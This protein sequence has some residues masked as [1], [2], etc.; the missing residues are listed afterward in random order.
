M[1]YFYLIASLGGALFVAVNLWAGWADVAHAVEGLGWGVVLI[2]VMRVV[3]TIA[4]GLALQPLTDIFSPISLARGTEIRWVRDAV[5]NL[6]PVASVGGEIIGARLLTRGGMSLGP[7]GASVLVDFSMQIASQLLFTIIGLVLLAELGVGGDVAWSVLIGL[8]IFTPAIGGFLLVQRRGGLQWVEGLLKR[9]A[10]RFSLGA[11]GDLSSIS[12]SADVL[13][14]RRWAVAQTFAVH[15]AIWF[16]G[17]VEIYIGLWFLGLEANFTTAVVIESLGQ[18]VK[19]A[20]FSVPGAIGVQE[21]GFIVLCAAF[22]IGPADAIALSLA[23][24]APDVALGV[25]GLIAW[26]YE[27]RR[28]RIA[29]LS[30]PR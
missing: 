5:N 15:L 1:N 8:L 12:D 26:Q 7:A 30:P 16:M 14:E 24:R 9:F 11:A 28:G 27:E 18:A 13:Y 29:A 21:G 22:G 2:I 20:A 4:G 23:K 17:A 10:Q 25:V 3:A 19:G 6:L